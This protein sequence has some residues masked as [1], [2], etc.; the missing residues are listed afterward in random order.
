MLFGHL[1][2]DGYGD[3]AALQCLHFQRA[4]EVCSVKHSPHTVGAAG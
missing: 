1:L 2:K 3:Y 4:L